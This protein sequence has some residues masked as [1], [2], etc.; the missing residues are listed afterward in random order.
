MTNGTQ[1]PDPNSQPG[2]GDP[3]GVDQEMPDPNAKGNTTEADARAAFKDEAG[4]G[5]PDGID[6]E[7]PT[8]RSS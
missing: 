4:G 7:T 6:P 5:D 1:K 2:G 3:S 8:S